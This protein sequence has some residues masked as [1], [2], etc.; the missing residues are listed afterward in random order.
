M[1]A[2]LIWGKAGQLRFENNEEYYYSLGL[3]CKSNW[4]SIVYEHNSQTN[5][6]A[7]AFRIQYSGCSIEKLPTG[8][9]NALRT[10]QRINNNEYVENLYHNHN[11]CYDGNKYI[12]GDYNNV[13]STVPE[14]YIQNFDLGYNL[15]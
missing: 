12:Y 6:W 14:E 5:S 11:F 15:N 7:D 9:R 13:R 4:F 10:Q 8:F 2:Q 1:M 3:L